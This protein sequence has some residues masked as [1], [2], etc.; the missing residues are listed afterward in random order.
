MPPEQPC[1]YCHTDDLED[2]EFVEGFVP[3]LLET[4]TEKYTELH[5]PAC[6]PLVLFLFCKVLSKLKITYIYNL[7]RYLV[8][9]LVGCAHLRCPFCC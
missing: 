9:L 8:F 1:K 4:S 6:A 2:S 3:S 5:P 7:I